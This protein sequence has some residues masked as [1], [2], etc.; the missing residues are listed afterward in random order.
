MAAAAT[1]NSP[2]GSDAEIG[3][4]FS[5]RDTTLPSGPYFL[6]LP[7]FFLTRSPG[8]AAVPAAGTT[9]GATVTPTVTTGGADDAGVVA[10]DAGTGGDCCVGGVA[11]LVFSD[12]I[13][14]A[15]SLTAAA[16]VLA[17]S[18]PSITHR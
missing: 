10:V 7:L 4:G 2:A 13:S 16:P 15:V 8:A 17:P 3:I 14:S 11:S 5:G 6:G 18:L 9:T 1:G 12:L